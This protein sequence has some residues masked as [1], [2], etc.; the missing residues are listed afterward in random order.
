MVMV[1]GPPAAGVL[2]VVDHVAPLVA[3]ILYVVVSQLVLMVMP[4]AGL[5]HPQSFTSDC[6]CNTMCEPIIAGSLTSADADT[7]RHE[8]MIARENIFVIWLKF[9]Y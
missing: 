3:V 6:C 7:K 1:Y 5:D 9:R 4:S 8:N 2:M